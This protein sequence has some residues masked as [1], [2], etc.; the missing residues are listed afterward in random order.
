MIKKI[1]DIHN[2]I[3][4][5]QKDESI[6]Y[7]KKNFYL[8]MSCVVPI[9]FCVGIV[10]M[11]ADNETVFSLFCLSI[12]LFAVIGSIS[13]SR[14]NNHLIFSFYF[15][16]LLNFILIPTMYF[17]NQGINRGVILLFV[18]GLIVTIVLLGRQ[19]Y[20]VIL[21]SIEFVYDIGIVIYTYFNTGKVYMDMSTFKPEY[22][23]AVSFAAVAFTVIFLF[24]YQNFIHNE[25]QK[26][27]ESNNDDILRAENT[28]GR[29]LANMT[30]EIRTPM[31]AI[32]G[33][34]DLI[35]KEDINKSARE[36]TDTIK[37]ASAQ[38][39]QIINNILEFSKLDSGRA[40]LINNEYSF[41]DLIVEIIDNVSDVY[42]KDE[43]DLH[44]YLHKNIPDILFGDDVRIKQVLRYLLLSP[45]SRSTNG[46]V[47]FSIDYDYDYDMRTIEFTFRI[48]STGDGLTDEEMVAIYN[49]YSNYDSRQKTDYKRTGLEFSICKKIL[50]M[51]NGDI[52]IDSIEGIGNALEFKFINYVVDDKPI[53]K[54]DDSENIQTLFYVANKKDEAAVRHTVEELGISAIYVRSPLRFRLALEKQ[55]Y[56]SIY[57]PDFVY[58]DVKEYI[59]AYGCAGSV[60]IITTSGHCIGEFDKCKILRRPVHLINFIESIDGSYDESKY[61]TYFDIDEIRYP[62]ARVLCVDDSIVN[63]KV[64]ENLLNDYDINPTTCTSGKEALEILEKEE[65]DIMFIDQKMPQMDGIEL[66]SRIKKL[67]NL[68]AFV[69]MICATADFGNDLR[70][71]LISYGFIDYL[72]KPINKIYLEKMLKDYLPEELRIITHKEK[73]EEDNQNNSANNTENKEEVNPLEFDP[74][75]GIQNLGGNKEAYLSVLLA[76]YDEGVEKIKLVP[77]Q[78]A[79]GNISLYTTNVHALKSSSATVGCMGVSPMFKALEFAGKDN[80]TEFIRENS[81]KTFGI[82]AEVLGKVREYL[83]SEDALEVNEFEGEEDGEIVSLDVELLGELKQ[84]ILSMNLRRAEEIIDSLS[85]CNFGSQINDIIRKI[86][87]SYDNFEYT[88][89]ITVIE[90][91]L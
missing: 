35:L 34:T 41:K 67:A 84:C 14:L 59:D 17:M 10:F 47:N 32:I 23:M 39:L 77:E 87:N 15:S 37:S 60:Y 16:I 56:K 12:G 24:E 89:I 2:N 83:E 1:V 19:K 6:S 52:T 85:H 63:V 64:F 72:A 74:E 78:F 70:D 48:A 21:V 91:N 71:E 90:D 44:V 58:N 49:A 79:E 46:S 9:M 20:I 36:Q 80:N 43:I 54:F 25:M 22:A 26:K 81:D 55:L 42:K 53:I 61:R 38:L 28:K 3:V 62:Y 8:A 18:L 13:A 50:N 40:E 29:F 75:V 86:K 73:T 88:E 45:L 31:N 27:V 57:V 51:M 4:R 7:E 5:F 76:Y 82:F 11:L 30:H 68:N 69:P 33:M 65:F 66:V